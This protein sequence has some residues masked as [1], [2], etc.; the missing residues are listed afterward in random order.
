MF[1]QSFEPGESTT[2]DVSPRAISAAA[3]EAATAQLS[4]IT[5]VSEFQSPDSACACVENSRA[6]SPHVP[7]SPLFFKRLPPHHFFLIVVEA[8]GAGGFGWLEMIAARAR[9]ACT[10]T[11]HINTPMWRVQ[12]SSHVT[13]SPEPETGLSTERTTTADT[14]VSIMA[15]ARIPTLWLPPCVRMCV[16]LCVCMYV[17]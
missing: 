2:R 17:D 7:H 14:K 8:S 11:S 6:P 10:L 12:L 1:R 9:A 16:C 15:E 4:V 13:T 3:T 5:C